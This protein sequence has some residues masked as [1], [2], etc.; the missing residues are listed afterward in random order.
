VSGRGADWW[1][2]APLSA[3]VMWISDGSLPFEALGLPSMILC[4]VYER[5]S[6]HLFPTV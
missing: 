3:K 4:M 1:A 5:P 6:L 2:K